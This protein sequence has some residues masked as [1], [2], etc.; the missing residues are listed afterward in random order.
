[1]IVLLSGEGITDIGMTTVLDRI[2]TPNEWVPGP[3]ALLVDQIF[4]NTF[5]Y[6]MIES[7]GYFVSESLLTYIAKKISIHKLRGVNTAKFHKK[8]SYALA[9]LQFS[10]ETATVHSPLPT[11]DIKLYEIAF[12]DKRVVLKVL[13]CIMA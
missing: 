13:E 6:S 5:H 4:Y 1:M 8:N 11:I 2:A 12:Q 10:L 9:S 3:M 7:S